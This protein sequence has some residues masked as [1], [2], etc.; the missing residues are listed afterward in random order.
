MNNAAIRKEGFRWLTVAA[1]ATGGVE[2]NAGRVGDPASVFEQD[3]RFENL[4]PTPPPDHG[5]INVMIF[6]NHELTPGAMVRSVI[7][8]AEAKTAALQE[9]AVN[10]RYSNRLA[11]GTGT[12]QI[13]VACLLGSGAPLTSAGKHSKLGELLGRTVHD[14][15]KQT[16]AIQNQLT[17]AG[18]CSVRIHLERF[19]ATRERLLEGVRSRL[20]PA[21]AKLLADNYEV[22]NRDPL[23]VAAV[24]AL[25]HLKDKLDWGV[26]P[27]QCRADILSA[28][29]AQTAAAV[30]GKY[31]RIHEYL[32]EL[33]PAP[34]LEDDQ[35]LLDLAFRALAAGY[36]DKLD[37]AS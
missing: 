6:I 12:D 13:G 31:E 3:G 15:V 8:A 34:G 1:A 9:L 18:Q 33:A 11:T 16:L 4:A 14:A 10:S 20:S 32:E 29:A 30:S 23:T 37:H 21:Q 17:P 2:T 28:H 35:G 7:T 19:G 27:A 25:V 26:L 5:T 24:A 36:R 22:M